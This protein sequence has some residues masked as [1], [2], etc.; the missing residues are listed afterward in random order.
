MILTLPQIEFAFGSF[1]IA[2]AIC[3]DYK[4]AVTS[5]TILQMQ[6]L[7]YQKEL[8]L[9]QIQFGNCRNRFTYIHRSLFGML[10]FYF[11]QKLLNCCCHAFSKAITYTDYVCMCLRYCE[12][13]YRAFGRV[14]IRER[15][16]NKSSLSVRSLDLCISHQSFLSC[17]LK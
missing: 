9:P 12:K 4:S 14:K 6:K 1:P 8:S 10:L 5:K 11:W 3:C 7:F 13:T 17:N 16:R 15:E 2:V